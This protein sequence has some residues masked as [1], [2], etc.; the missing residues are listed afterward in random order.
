MAYHA[1]MCVAGCSMESASLLCTVRKSLEM[2]IE[3]I[4]CGHIYNFKY[5]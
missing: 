3:L 5:V 4:L 2:R 1:G